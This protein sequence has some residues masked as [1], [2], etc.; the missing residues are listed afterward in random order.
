MNFAVF[1][2]PVDK[3]FPNLSPAAKGAAITPSRPDPIPLTTPLT[4]SCFP[5]L[6]GF[7]KMPVIPPKSSEKPP[8]RPK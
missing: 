7:V 8:L 1:L 4:P 5:F 2:I 6:Y 3:E